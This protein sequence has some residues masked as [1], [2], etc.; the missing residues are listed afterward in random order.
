MAPEERGAAHC[1]PPA[2]RGTAAGGERGGRGGE[3][4]ENKRTL[5][6]LGLKRKNQLLSL[7]KKEK[8]FL[9]IKINLLE[10]NSGCIDRFTSV[11]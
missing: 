1:T 5:E 7:K 11:V 4:Q 2:G 8:N 10:N 9:N 3:N 6:K